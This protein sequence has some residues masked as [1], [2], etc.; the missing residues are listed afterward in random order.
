MNT[1]VLL[2]G[3][4]VAAFASTT[5]AT[6][7]L[8]SPR[9]QANQ[10]KV[11]SSLPTPVTVAAY[12]DSSAALLSPRAQANQPKIVRGT[13]SESNPAM[14]CRKDMKTSPRAA[15]ECSSHT[16]MPDCAKQVAA[17]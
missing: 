10:P 6:D 2:L 1:K 9:A 7:A 16:T 3:A 8:L 11:I 12:V 15:G 14:D 13:G 5:F 17:K 4:V